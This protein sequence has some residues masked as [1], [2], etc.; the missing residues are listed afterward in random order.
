[1]DRDL[2]S[3]MAESEGWRRNETIA[4]KIVRNGFFLPF[5]TLPGGGWLPPKQQKLT[6]EELLVLDK[7]RQDMLAGKRLVVG[8]DRRYVHTAFAVKND[9]VVVAMDKGIN[10]CLHK[11]PHFRLPRLTDLKSV[12]EEGSFFFKT[13]IRKSFYHI[14]IHKSHQHFLTVSLPV[15][16]RDSRL[17][18]YVLYKFTV[19]PMGMT[20]SPYVNT[21]VFNE[22]VLIIRQSEIVTHAYIDDFLFTIVDNFADCVE[23]V[24]ST[25]RYFGVTLSEEKSVWIPTQEMEFLGFTL[26][27]VLNEIR[28]TPKKKH[29]GRALIGMALHA[30]AV[31]GRVGKRQLSQVVGFLQS[32]VVALPD[33]NV[34]LRLLYNAMWAKTEFDKNIGWNESLVLAE[35]DLETFK[36]VKQLLN[37]QGIVR[38]LRSVKPERVNYTDASGTML[39]SVLK[40]IELIEA[41]EYISAK[42]L[43]ERYPELGELHEDDLITHGWVPSEL[44]EDSITAKE[45]LAV[46]DNL[47]KV[48]HDLA[49]LKVVWCIDNLGVCFC[50]RKWRSKIP[51]IHALILRIRALL[52]LHGIEPTA[53]LHVET[54]SNLS[55][56]P[57]RDKQQYF[58][59]WCFADVHFKWLCRSWKLDPTRFDVDLFAELWNSKCTQYFSKYFDGTSLGVESLAQTWNIFEW[60]WCNPPFRLAHMVFEKLLWDMPKNVILILPHGG[61]WSDLDNLHV[62]LRGKAFRWH[63]LEPTADL[64]ESPLSHLFK[65]KVVNYTFCIYWLRRSL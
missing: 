39:G 56:A 61:K 3:I 32:L 6:I 18:Y 12:V 35:Q 50:L 34:F 54:Q 13:D 26:D 44:A 28:I 46:V 25:F 20:W 8:G 1:M 5:E 22:I 19:L 40:R 45:M 17:L 36:S 29:T 60:A 31:T 41:R 7:W 53:F 57:S 30:Q 24:Q 55:D 49:G 2:A 16:G 14:R 48:G 51:I 4:G 52:L 11:P 63:E 15:L 64:F 33:I 37:E 65:P 38:R 9:R 62:K 10:P 42:E 47:E 21:L 43:V 27:N 58:D 59:S 23:L